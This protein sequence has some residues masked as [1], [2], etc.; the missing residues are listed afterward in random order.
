MTDA[1]AA[2]A[3]MPESPDLALS[4]MMLMKQRNKE[5]RAMLLNRMYSFIQGMDYAQARQPNPRP[6]KRTA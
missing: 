3:T 1:Q 2:T 4:T 5:E 6:S